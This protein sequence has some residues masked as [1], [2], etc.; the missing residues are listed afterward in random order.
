MEKIRGNV[1]ITELADTARRLCELFKKTS[2]VQNDD[3]LSLSFAEVEKQTNELTAAVKKDTIH[4]NLEKADQERDHAIRVLDKLLK[5]YEHIPVEN[6]QKH[7]KKLLPVFN[8]YGVRITSENYATLSTL[9]ISML[10]DFS[11]SHLSTSVEA[12]IGVKESLNNIRTKQAAFDAL[13]EAYEGEVAIQKKRA[14]ATVLRK[15]LLELVNKK[16]VPYLV[17]MNIA[18]PDSFKEFISKASEIVTSTNEAVKSR[19]KKS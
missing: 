12:L 18:Q 19:E 6:M 7:A 11:A 10:E 9:I 4:S 8:K 17:A 13:R 16:I 14:S 1:R 2:L 3:F 5:G 15:P